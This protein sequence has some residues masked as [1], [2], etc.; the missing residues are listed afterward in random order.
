MKLITALLIILT[1]G[2]IMAGTLDPTQKKWIDRYQK[3]KQK[4]LPAAKDMLLNTDPEPA[5]KDGFTSLFNGTD[6]K[7]KE[8]K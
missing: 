2:S 5:L 4:N 8:L 6:L 3:Q 1:A 7:V